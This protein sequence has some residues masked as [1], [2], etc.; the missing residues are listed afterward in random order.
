MKSK[1]LCVIFGLQFSIKRLF[2]EFQVPRS[3]IS[4]QSSERFLSMWFF[5][6]DLSSIV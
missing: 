3:V 2:R 6:K 1:K 4:I 5:S